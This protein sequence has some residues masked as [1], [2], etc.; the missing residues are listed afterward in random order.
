MEMLAVDA[1]CEDG[2]SWKFVLSQEKPVE[3]GSKDILSRA[4]QEALRNNKAFISKCVTKQKQE[5]S[6][7]ATAAALPD[8]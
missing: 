1:M 2:H 7:V 4:I 6:I 3:F 8:S 5:D